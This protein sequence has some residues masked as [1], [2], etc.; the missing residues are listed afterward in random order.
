VNN[1][2]RIMALR[3]KDA[4]RTIFLNDGKEG[5]INTIYDPNSDQE[6]FQVFIH[7]EFPYETVGAW[8]FESFAQARSFACEKFAQNWEMLSW[9]GKVDRPCN[10]ENCGEGRSGNCAECASGG[11]CKSCGATEDLI[12]S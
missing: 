5:G 6:I 3:E 12:L 11:G 10:N 2:I 1:L 8:E 4:I 7:N 9:D